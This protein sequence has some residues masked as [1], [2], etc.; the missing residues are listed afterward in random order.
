MTD[1]EF[2]KRFSKISITELCKKH[3]IDKSNLWAGRSKKEYATIIRNE[4]IM[5][6]MKILSD[7]IDNER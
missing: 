3:S 1:L 6:F 5:E 2:I 7:Y 4:L